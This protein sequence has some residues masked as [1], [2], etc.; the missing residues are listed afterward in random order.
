MAGARKRTVFVQCG[1]RFTTEE[2]ENIRSM[3]ELFPRLSRHELARTLCENLD[4]RTASGGY[5][6]DA[7]LKLLGK[8]AAQGVMR[9]PEKFLP[10][11]RVKRPR[12]PIRGA[13]EGEARVQI[14]GSLAEVGPVSLELVADKESKRAWNEYVDRYHYLGYKQPFGC[15]L[16]YFIVSPRGLLGCV[17]LAGASK[18]IGVRDRWIGWPPKRRMRNLPWIVNNSRFL[19]FPWV[20]VPHLAS[21]VLGRIAR[22]VRDDW[23]ERFGYR[24]VMLETF[25]DP[26]LYEGTCYRAAG[27]IKL[28]ET[29]GHGL[30]RPGCTYSTSPKVIFVQPLV[31]DFRTLLCSESLQGRTLDEE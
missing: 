20:D 11:V 6:E 18:S 15:R 28:G 23:Y 12:R 30:V 26:K 31:A 10:G 24:P 8:L 7:C 3:V 22:R 21:H 14:S 16:Y 25:V 2:V 27:W 13:E 1:R 5:K 29:D 4:W 19:I 17:L 9:L